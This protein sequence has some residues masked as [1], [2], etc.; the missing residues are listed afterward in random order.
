MG[1]PLMSSY[2]AGRGPR[3]AGAQARFRVAALAIVTTGVILLAAAA[4]VLSYAG[5]H[6][7]ALRAGVAAGPARLYPVTF[8]A[9]LVIAGA[10]A[11]ALRGAGRW[12]RAYAWSTLLVLLAAV[13]TGDALHAMNVALPAQ[14]AR[15]AV[16]V[17][18][19]ALVL[20]AF[21]LLL[22][23]LRYVRKTRVAGAQQART[24]ALAGGAGQPLAG[25]R[26]NG[27]SDPGGE[28]AG[29]QTSVTWASAGNAGESRATPPSG[30]DLLLGPRPPESYAPVLSW[31]GAGPATTPAPRPPAGDDVPAGGEAASGTVAV[32]PAV[33]EEP[34]G[35][36]KPAD[37]PGHPDTPGP[38]GT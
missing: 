22:E 17:L 23:M 11:L 20:L 38:A 16:A 14:P 3:P 31:A 2:P 29:K 15:A 13:A 28:A 35:L 9:M 8:D 25:G 34:A 37:E 4:F 5:I 26:A 33:A 32:P 10:A 6:Q 36:P 18:P 12:P 1:D 19:W 7:I 24:A 30:L 21:G 27:A